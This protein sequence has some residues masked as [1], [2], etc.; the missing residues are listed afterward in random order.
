[1]INHIVVVGI[2][3]KNDSVKESSY[4]FLNENSKRKRKTQKCTTL[5]ASASDDWQEPEGGPV[6]LFVTGRKKDRND[7]NKFLL[8]KDVA[9]RIGKDTH[10]HRLVLQVHFEVF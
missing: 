9:F 2:S 6:N 10:V 7:S 1:M 8:P 3:S 4:N 5:S